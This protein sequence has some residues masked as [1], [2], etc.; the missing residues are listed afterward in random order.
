MAFSLLL[1]TGCF[2]CPNLFSSSAEC[3]NFCL[4]PRLVCFHSGS[5]PELLIFITVL[6]QTPN[7]CKRGCSNGGTHACHPGAET[8][9]QDWWCKACPCVGVPCGLVTEALLEG[10]TH[11]QGSV[12]GRERFLSPVHGLL[13]CSR[14]VSST[15]GQCG[16]HPLHAE[17]FAYLCRMEAGPSQDEKAWMILFSPIKVLL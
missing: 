2:V 12:W 11:S 1:C 6:L 17:G 3:N 4:L 13:L 9:L 10:G 8:A 14:S 15:S 16:G 7:P 5:F